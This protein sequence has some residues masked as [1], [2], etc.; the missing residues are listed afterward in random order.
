MSPALT[1][2]KF[3]D[4]VEDLILKRMHWEA[5]TENAQEDLIRSTGI[6]DER[7]L[8]ELVRLGITKS[9]L[10]ALRM[11]PFVLVAWAEQRVDEKE[12]AVVLQAAAD[13]GIVEGSD[14][15]LLLEHWLHKLPSQECVDAWKR[16][17][18]IIMSKMSPGARQKLIRLTESQLKE[19]ACASGGHLWFGR[20]TQKEQQMIDQLL[21]AM[22][23]QAVQ[24]SN[25][26]DN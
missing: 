12:H 26:R 8:E 23:E 18:R 5:E 10:I 14:A 19:V 6:D 16:H 22:R 4:D 11:L 9:T 1:E 21:R 2:K 24:Q 15:R 20:I 17:M 7:L 13:V 3:F 25:R